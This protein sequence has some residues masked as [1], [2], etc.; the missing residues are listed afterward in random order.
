[1][2]DWDAVIRERLYGEAVPGWSNEVA[3]ELADH[4]EDS[5]EE[6]R[7]NGLCEPEAVARALG[8]VADWRGLARQIRKAKRSGHAIN[9]RTKQLLLPA[10]VSL[11]G[12]NAV[13]MVLT[14]ISLDP[15]M[16]ASL[17]N[18]WFPG[19]SLMASYMPWLTAQPLIGALGAHLSYRAGGSRVLRLTAALF[20]SIVMLGCWTFVIT[21]SA[22]FE[23]HAWVIDHLIYLAVG[24]FAWVIP[25]AM[26]LFFGSLPFLCFGHRE[27]APRIIQP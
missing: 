21:A 24:T 12:A 10:L 4:L 11:T 16:I 15:R 23:R 9:E 13:L 17:S 14:R 22:L 26:G 1:M 27:M 5:Y 8:D 19:F 20:P 2:R 18:S 6:L 3:A 25:A 7:T